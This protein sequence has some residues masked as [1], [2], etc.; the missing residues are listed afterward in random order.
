MH[1]V[2]L[3]VA[4]TNP[5][6][7]AEVREYLSTFPMQLISLKELESYPTVEED[8]RTFEENAATKARTVA[9]ATGL[10]TVAHD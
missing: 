9:Q 2:P 3:V 8:G 4:T 6:K 10:L 1:S 5:G 7:L